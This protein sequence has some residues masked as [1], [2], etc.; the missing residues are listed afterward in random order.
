MTNK[1]ITKIW[2]EEPLDTN[3]FIANKA[4]CHGFDVYGDMLGKASW[5][6]MTWLL[7]KGEPANKTQLQLF[8]DLALAIAN[9]GP[10]DPSVHAAMCAGT[11]GSTNA[12]ALMAALA[13]GAGQ[14]GGAREVFEA[15]CALNF[16]NK[17]TA[18]FIERVSFK[19]DNAT[20]WPEHKSIIGFDNNQEDSPLVVQLLEHLSK[21]KNSNHLAWLLENKSSLEAKVCAKINQ[22]LVAA[23]AF[24]DLGFNA[25]ESEMLYLLL[26]LPG[27]AA[28]AL[29]QKQLGPKNFPFFDLDLQNDPEKSNE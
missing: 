22:Q 11:G 5:L 18:I 15:V 9:P 26:R 24:I 12:S 14:K 8:E 27:A 13:V 23:C 21:N 6:Q 4:F 2:Q 17:D 19:D 3:A 20:I 1:V 10:R 7:F 29:E 28:H 16:S 25:E